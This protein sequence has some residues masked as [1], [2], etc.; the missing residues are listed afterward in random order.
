[1]AAATQHGLV[2]D[3]S[4]DGSSLSATPAGR[5]RCRME[6][7]SDASGNAIDGAAS[8][9]GSDHDAGFDGNTAS[10]AAGEYSGQ[11]SSSKCAA[12]PV[13]APAVAVPRVA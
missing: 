4:V 12:L 2:D 9:G 13:L 3:G 5:R 7:S 1:M 8:D 11:Q 10:T 6:G